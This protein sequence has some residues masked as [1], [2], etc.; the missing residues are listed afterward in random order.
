M[1]ETIESALATMIETIESTLAIM[2]Y[3]AH[4]T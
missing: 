2:R 4:S 1:I 3:L